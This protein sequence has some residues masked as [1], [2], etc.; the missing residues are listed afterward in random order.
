ML[1]NIEF[2]KL[3]HDIKTVAKVLNFIK[4]EQDHDKRQ[5]FISLLINEMDRLYKDILEMKE[6]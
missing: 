5:T 2:E 6:N 3:L 4:I 1:T